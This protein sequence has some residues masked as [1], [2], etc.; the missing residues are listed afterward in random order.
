MKT[1]SSG[2]PVR[3]SRRQRILWR[4]LPRPKRSMKTSSSQRDPE[5][6]ENAHSYVIVYNIIFYINRIGYLYCTWPLS[7]VRL[8]PC[9]FYFL[10]TADFITVP[11]Q[12]NIDHFTKDVTLRNLVTLSSSTF[13]LAQKRIYALMEKDSFGRFLRSDQYL[14]LLVN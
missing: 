11:Q 7:N 6:S 12:V 3:T 2:W 8:Y 4:W 10:L 9:L 14:E 1:S 5:R 13:D